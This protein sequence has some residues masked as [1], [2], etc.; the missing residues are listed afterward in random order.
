MRGG[1]KLEAQKSLYIEGLRLGPKHGF[2]C[3]ACDVQ[4]QVEERQH[5]LVAPERASGFHSIWGGLGL[6]WVSGLKGVLSSKR[7][8]EVPAELSFQEDPPGSRPAGP[9]LSEIRDWLHPTG[10]PSEGASG[11]PHVRLVLI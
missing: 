2:P 7:W 9:R 11:R 3:Q 6:G 1:D 4:K 8:G 10:T 5:L